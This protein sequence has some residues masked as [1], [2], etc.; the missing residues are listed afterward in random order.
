MLHVVAQYSTWYFAQMPEYACSILHGW[1][2]SMSQ[3]S[4]ATTTS[5]INAYG[6][7]DIYKSLHFPTCSFPV[8]ANVHRQRAKIHAPQP[9]DNP[10]D[11]ITGIA[12]LYTVMMFNFT[13]QL[14]SSLN[15]RGLCFTIPGVDVFLSK[16]ISQDPLQQFFECQWQCGSTSENPTAA[17]FFKHLG[18]PGHQ[19]CLRGSEQRIL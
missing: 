1:R 16:K 19:L 2:W 15:R 3:Y 17:E 4:A 13:P 8:Q 9:R 5:K 6:L 7:W 10:G 18:T 11:K 12:F 14:N